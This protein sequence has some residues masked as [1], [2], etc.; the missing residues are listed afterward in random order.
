MAKIN[1][2]QKKLLELDGGAF[3]KLADSYLLKRGYRQINPIGS[4]IASNK[5]KK[6]T[7][8]TLIPLS[9]GKYIF[10]EY[11]TQESNVFDKF[12]EDIKKC[13]NKEQTGIPI[14]KIQEVVLC[15]TTEL[16]PKDLESLRIE[17]AKH[18][19]NLNV[20]GMGAISYDLLVKFPGIAKDYLNV[21][22]D[23]GQ[24]VPIDEFITYYGRNKL[25]ARLDTA[26]HFRE[27]EIKA[28][29]TAL[30]KGDLVIISGHAG[31][32]KSRLALECCEKFSQKHSSCK[33][34]CIQN[35]GVDLFEDLRVHFSEP[36]EFL[37]LVDDAN[38]ISGFR[39][40]IDLLQDRRSD[41]QIKVVATVRDYA[42]D[43]VKEFCLPY[44]DPFEINL[45][46]LSENQVEQLVEEECGIKN[47]LYLE[48]INKISQGNPRLAIMAAEIAKG[49]NTIESIRD[50]SELYD[51]Y[52]RSIR[53]DLQELKDPNILKVAGIVSFFGSVDRSYEE[54]MTDIAN[55]FSIAKDDLWNAG[56]ILHNMEIFDMYEN[57]VLKASD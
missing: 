5:V 4:V 33:V 43:S 44:G 11:T 48:Q 22:V 24:I 6:G 23:T 16:S 27:E 3:Q 42:L 1:Q 50:A 20:F 49:K 12:Y 10:A 31:V 7:P 55:V 41:R 2:I 19:V 34:Q 8:D 36:G 47:H 14:E 35:K 28:I 17:C 25:A 52:Y 53:T 15:H 56:K 38:R 51:Q 30:E 32:G 13:F 39:H 21:E 37:I 26:F 54:L 18:R 57:E 9:D 40:F 45:Q 46:P 29:E